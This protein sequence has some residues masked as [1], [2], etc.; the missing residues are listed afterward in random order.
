CVERR[1]CYDGPRSWAPRWDGRTRMIRLS[2]AGRRHEQAHWDRRAKAWE[3]WEPVLL[4]SLSAVSPVLI[5]ALDLRR[6]QRV[7]DLGCGSGDPSLEVAQWVGPRGRVLGIDAS[8][9]MLATAGRRARLLGLKNVRFRR[10][11]I[12]RFSPSGP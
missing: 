9:T 3:R 1:L 2:A 4:H 5:R 6:G 11:D 10:G 8:P 12:A 7:V